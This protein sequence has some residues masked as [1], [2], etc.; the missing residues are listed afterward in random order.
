MAIVTESEYKT[1][2]GI[3]STDYDTILA[4]LVERSTDEIESLCG[5]T[6]GGFE[7]DTFTETFDGED[8][9][10]LRVSNGPIS[11]ITSIKLGNST[12]STVDSSAYVFRD[13]TIMSAAGRDGSRVYRDAY[14][15]VS[16]G[17]FL[18]PLGTNNIEVVYVTSDARD[19]LLKGAAFR[20]IDHYLDSRG[21]DN[22]KLTEALGTTTTV[23]ASPDFRDRLLHEL[24][25][26]RVPV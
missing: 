19:D 2:R 25:H 7:G 16:D 8:T 6:S 23:R 15:S 22:E 21:R 5:R 13:R 12:Q 14:G 3:A 9:D 1:Y 26:W 24:R 11:S 17:S 20:L 18:F 4:D 10:I